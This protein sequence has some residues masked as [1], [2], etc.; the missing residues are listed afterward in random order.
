MDLDISLIIYGL[1][2]GLCAGA[3]AGVL[4]GLAGLGGGLI[5]V[6]VFY[7]FLPQED[8]SMAL[9]VFASMVAVL[10]TAGFSTRAHWR[11]GHIDISMLKT[12]L[13]GLLLGAS[14]GLWSTLFWPE[15]VL[16][17]ALAALNAWV[18]YDY[19]RPLLQRQ[20]AGCFLRLITWPMGYISGLLGIGGGTM[21]VP[22]LR[23][24]LSL[25]QA[26]GTASACALVMVFTA[27]LLNVLWE[28]H[29]QDLLA[30]QGVLLLALAAGVLLA[31]PLSSRWAA[32]LHE[33][34]TEA[35]LQEWLKRLFSLI[36]FAFICLAGFKLAS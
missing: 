20:V 33:K 7:L 18:A 14:L 6:P 31:M 36:S 27:L 3:L 32:Y 5:Y 24:S 13:P 16:L 12:L 10:F 4:A 25:K 22:L 11:L 35:C 8:A 21:L 23:R 34:F 19:A 29:W 2:I 17:L 26:V 1:S 9:P 15:I 30:E 28:K